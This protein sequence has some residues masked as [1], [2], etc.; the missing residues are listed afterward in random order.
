MNLLSTINTFMR[1]RETLYDTAA[2]GEGLGKLCAKLLAIF[3]LT[4]AIYGLV[5]GGFRWMH[6]EYSFSDFALYPKGQPPPEATSSY[7]DSRGVD[8]R[9]YTE[10][11]TG[12]VLGMSVEELTIYTDRTALPILESPVVHFNLSHPTAPY[13]VES[14][15]VTADGKYGKIVLA[16]GSML[17]EPDAWKLPLL[18]AG[19][20]PLL[21]L[22]TL[23]ICSAALYVMNLA[24]GLRLHFMP[25][26][27]LMV[28]GL[29]ATGIMLCVFAPIAG[30]FTVSTRSYHFIKLMHVLVFI[31][32]G[33]FG[34]KVLGQGLKRMTTNEI[35]SAA[36]KVI[37]R[38]RGSSL[39]LAWMGL[40]CVVGAQLAWMLKPFLG[41]PY[42]PSTP[43]FRL[44]EGNIYVSFFQSLGQLFTGFAGR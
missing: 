38:V 4:M 17:C 5:M 25:T 37:T 9:I 20:I 33:F 21:F 15:G 3:L 22:L 44:E 24:F 27:T 2:S 16:A 41:T 31:V 36:H 10:N 34:V 1:D 29:A 11:M 39:L 7:F 23:L 12:K 8:R 6:P 30:L 32:A 14:V 42:L 28:F 40:Y 43:P 35:D 18:V 13:T 26:I 19:K